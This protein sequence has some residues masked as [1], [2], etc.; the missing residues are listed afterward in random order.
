MGCV[1]LRILSHS[2]RFQ[3]FFIQNS[4]QNRAYRFLSPPCSFSFFLD[5]LLSAFEETGS[6][7]LARVFRV[8]SLKLSPEAK[9]SGFFFLIVFSVGWISFLG[10]LFL[11]FAVF[12]ILRSHS[13]VWPSN[14]FLYLIVPFWYASAAYQ[15]S[16]VEP[17][18][19]FWRDAVEPKYPWRDQTS[20]ICSRSV[21]KR[22]D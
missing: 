16:L 1:H 2:E 13:I 3:P 12:S 19:V 14:Q 8:L 10:I 6:F 4:D 5:E 7:S 20:L 11:S 18:F 9:T 17:W 21:P 15:A 22:Y